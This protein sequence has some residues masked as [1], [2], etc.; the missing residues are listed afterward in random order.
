MRLSSVMS[1]RTIGFPVSGASWLSSNNTNGGVS[2]NA[3]SL[4]VEG[5]EGV[6]ATADSMKKLKTAPFP[7]SLVT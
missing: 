4:S 5:V 7:S 1:T 6:D 3:R 2:G